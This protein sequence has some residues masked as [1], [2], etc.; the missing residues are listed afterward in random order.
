MI[1]RIKRLF[2]DIYYY[3]C[4]H[5]MK[6]FLMVIMPLLTGGVLQKLLAT[7]GVSL[8]RGLTNSLPGGSRGLG[9]EF[10]AAGGSGLG[11]SVNSLMSVAKMFM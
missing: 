1:H 9:G 7:V 4:R 11:Q 6:V 8:P 3:A 5:P 10:G 2:K